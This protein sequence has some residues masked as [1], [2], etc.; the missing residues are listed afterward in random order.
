[1]ENPEIAAVVVPEGVIAF[2]DEWHL[3]TALRVPSS[4]GGLH[5]CLSSRIAGE[6]R[7]IFIPISFVTINLSSTP[8]DPVL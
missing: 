7:E 4:Q 6:R 3:E 2:K 5:Y 8:L 1:M